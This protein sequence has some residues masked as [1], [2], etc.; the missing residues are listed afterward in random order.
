MASAYEQ[1]LAATIARVEDLKAHGV[2]YLPVGQETL[3]RLR[4]A[5]IAPESES[6]SAPLATAVP[7]PATSLPRPAT[8]SSRSNTYRNWS[9]RS[10]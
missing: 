2:K 1:L 3:E 9:I 7:Q 6:S 8:P 10:V 4:Q 5:P